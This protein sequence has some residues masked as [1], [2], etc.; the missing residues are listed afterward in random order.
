M[1]SRLLLQLLP[2]IGRVAAR[3]GGEELAGDR[4]D[5]LMAGPVIGGRVI[6]AH[7]DRRDR[8]VG[9]ELAILGHRR[10]WRAVDVGLAA[11]RAIELRADPDRAVHAAPGESVLVQRALLDLEQIGCL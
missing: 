4:R 8:A 6:V 10:G 3:V 1:L 7:D 11:D 5:A 2:Q 9:V